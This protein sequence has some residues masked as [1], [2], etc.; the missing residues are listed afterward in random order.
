MK[1]MRL[2]LIS[3]LALILVGCGHGFEGTYKVEVSSV[4]VN[5]SELM[6]NNRIV[7]GG[8]YLESDGERTGMDKIFVRESGG[9]R[10]LVFKD[11]NKEEAWK[12]IDDKTL[13]K[14]SGFAKVRM[15]RID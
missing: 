7:I 15:S 9:S 6:P 5:L 13:E 1:K 2:L 11:K 10:Y 3:M 4:G 14:G 8:D 12:I